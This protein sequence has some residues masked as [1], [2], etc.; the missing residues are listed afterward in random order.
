MSEREIEGQKIHRVMQR[1][2]NDNK[3][4]PTGH[5]P[6]KIYLGIIWRYIINSVP[7]LNCI[8]T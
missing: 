3:K 2:R 6:F 7:C 1:A 8:A 5:F 4:Q